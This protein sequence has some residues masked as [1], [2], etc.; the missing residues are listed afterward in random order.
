MSS[1]FYKIK[2]AVLLCA[3][4]ATTFFMLGGMSRRASAQAPAEQ[5]T[6][7]E[8]RGKRIYLKGETEGPAEIT[9]LLGGDETEI[10]AAA[11]ACANCHGLNGEGKEE[12]GLT[13]PALVWSTLT[14]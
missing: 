13:A 1:P 4:L 11:F 6:A 5:L 2:L 7:A 12:G 9:A 3:L 14:A 10:P 8:R